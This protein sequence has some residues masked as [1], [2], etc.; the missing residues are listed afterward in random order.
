M[1]SKI[2]NALNAALINNRAETVAVSNLTAAVASAVKL[3]GGAVVDRIHHD[4]VDLYTGGRKW[5]RLVA[6]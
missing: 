3:L 4:T 2:H 1:D 6:A 5:L